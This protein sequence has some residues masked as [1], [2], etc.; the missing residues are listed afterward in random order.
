MPADLTT[1][2]QRLV[3]RAA[4]AQAEQD[5]YPPTP[6]V[7]R[8]YRED[9]RAVAAAVLQGILPARWRAGADVALELAGL[10]RVPLDELIVAV[11]QV[12]VP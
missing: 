8:Q 7:L 6:G 4:A 5:G 1:L 12:K 2:A 9:A 3:D 10:G 11:E